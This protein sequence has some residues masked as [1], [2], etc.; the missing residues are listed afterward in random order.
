VGV[1]VQGAAMS[2]EKNDNRRRCWYC[3]DGILIWG[4][5]HDAEDEE[6][7]IVTNLSCS[8]CNAYYEVSWGEKN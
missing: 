3:Q 1:N 5:D 2:E 4:A 8:S 6:H 7:L